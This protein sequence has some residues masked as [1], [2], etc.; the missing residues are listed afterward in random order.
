MS[1]RVDM[2]DG[3]NE[4]PAAERSDQSISLV[5]PVTLTFCNLRASEP[6]RVAI[7]DELAARWGDPI[8]GSRRVGISFAAC[9]RGSALYLNQFVLT[10]KALM[11]SASKE[12]AEVRVRLYA[13][14]SCDYIAG[15]VNLPNTAFAILESAVDRVVGVRSSFTLALR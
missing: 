11:F 12:C 15:G 5:Y 10:G 7:L 9:P 4:T 1:E 14:S 13:H 2:L 8:A 3:N 6:A